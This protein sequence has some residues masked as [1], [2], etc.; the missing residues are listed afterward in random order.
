MVSLSDVMRCVNNFFEEGYEDGEFNITLEGEISP[1]EWIEQAHYIAVQGSFYNDG[2]YELGVNGEIIGFGG[3]PETFT[4]RVWILRPPVRFIQLFEEICEFDKHSPKSSLISESFG[5]YS[6]TRSNNY[7]TGLPA[8]WE[9]I[10]QASLR[11]FR[12][13]YTEVNV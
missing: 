7:D 9:E 12:N 11:P 8:G 10:Y 3:T 2:V 1:Y 13:M 6:R 4:G 5:S